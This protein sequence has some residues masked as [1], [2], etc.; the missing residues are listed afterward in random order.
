M[1]IEEGQKRSFFDELY[2]LDVS[3]TSVNDVD[4]LLT[5]LK[6]IR[7]ARKSRPPSPIF[8]RR[9]ANQRKIQS[10]ERA[11]SAPSRSITTTLEPSLVKA[12]LAEGNVSSEAAKSPVTT[13]ILV[14]TAGLQPH[15][16]PSP[17]IE[18]S[19]LQMT[20]TAKKRKRGRSVDVLPEAQRIFSGRRFC[21][22]FETPLLTTLIQCQTFFQMMMWPLHG[23]YES[24]K[25]LREVEY[26]SETTAMT[27]L[28]L[29]STGS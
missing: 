19:P 27:L 17:Q 13:S 5:S 23:D 28:I 18:T 22:L 29:F 25:S 15:V 4:S 14:G 1:N 2:E 16:V 7:T 3:D 20:A 12:P 9:R 26:G 8:N 10:L 6:A 11:V 21:K 24:P